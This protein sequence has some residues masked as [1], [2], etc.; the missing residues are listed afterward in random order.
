MSTDELRKEI[1]TLR[2]MVIGVAGM[3][4]RALGYQLLAV[5]CGVLALLI[6]CT[7]EKWWRV[8]LADFVGCKPD[9][10]CELCNARRATRWRGGRF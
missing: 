8:R 9:C 6:I 10:R 7:P 4:S 2:G 1:H 5:L 3:A